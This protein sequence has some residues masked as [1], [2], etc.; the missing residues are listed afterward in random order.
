MLG[1]LILAMKSACTQ[2]IGV[3]SR[4]LWLAAL[5]MTLKFFSLFFWQVCK[6]NPVA[7]SSIS[8]AAP[9]CISLAAAACQRLSPR[10]C[11]C[12]SWVTPARP[13]LSCVWFCIITVENIF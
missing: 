1:A 7:V 4:S 12:M 9:L 3:S 11:P 2:D 13:A 8:L 5:Q 10:Y 6:L